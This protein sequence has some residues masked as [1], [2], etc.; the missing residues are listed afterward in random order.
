MKQIITLMVAAAAISAWGADPYKVQV[1]A[2]GADAEGKT[3]YIYN[4]DTEEVVDST[5]VSQGVA[6]FS[7]TMDEAIP[8]IIR[9]EEVKGGAFVLE[10]GSIA[11]SDGD[12]FGSPLNDTYRAMG[13]SLN[14]KVAAVR[15]ATD[16][17]SGEAAFNSLLSYVEAQ[18]GQ[19]LDNP[20]SWFL[21]RSFGSYLEP[22][23]IKDF[24][25]REPLFANTKLTK[26][27]LDAIARREAT[28]VGQKYT[29]F[30]VNGQKLSDFVG[31]DGHY[32]LVDFWA[33]WCGP[34]IRQTVVLKELYNK[35]K[36]KGLDVLGVAVWDEPE[37]TKRAIVQHQLPWECI[38]DAQRIPTDIYGIQGI[39]CIML[40]GPDGTILSRDKQ[41]DEL[42]ADVE[43][44]LGK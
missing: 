42:V 14:Q 13:D 29:D 27:I 26:K 37:D 5:V 30:E 34:C 12:A 8:A 31:K 35:Y 22:A 1:P 17:A 16:E 28:A 40:I 11:F 21:M 20:I 19:N 41:G 23:T 25:A 15:A 18:I 9:N 24:A 44:Y 38:I 36:D 39:P 3:V 4:T 6:L 10:P 2:A 43:K 7:G 32:L 33:S